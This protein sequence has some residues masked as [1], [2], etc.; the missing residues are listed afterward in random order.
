ML[1]ALGGPTDASQTLVW[2]LKEAVLKARQI[3][4]RAG[5]LSVRLSDLDAGQQQATATDADGGLW[6]LSFERRGD[7]WVSVAVARG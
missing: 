4:L 6:R 7:L 3:G 1:E 5:M 2:S